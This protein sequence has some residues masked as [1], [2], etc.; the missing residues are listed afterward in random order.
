M[1]ETFNGLGERL[2]R[3]GKT[4]GMRQLESAICAELREM[5]NIPRIRVKDMLAWNTGSMEVEKADEV[6]VYLPA[7][8]IQVCIN[9]KL[10]KRVKQ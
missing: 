2:K 1:R 6:V 10:D 3:G 7:L 9:S 5:V 8:Q 4:M